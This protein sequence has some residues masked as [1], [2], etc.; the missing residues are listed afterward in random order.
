MPFGEAECYLGPFTLGGN[1][2]VM[3]ADLGDANGRYLDVEAI[4]RWQASD[5]LEILAGYRYLVIDGFGRATDRDFDA[6]IDLHGWFIG[7][8][9]RF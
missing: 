2:S 1:A 6:D 9:V 5:D 4:A 7:G 8:G 3:S